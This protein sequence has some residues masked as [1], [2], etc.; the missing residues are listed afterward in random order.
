MRINKISSGLSEEKLTMASIFFV[1]VFIFLLPLFKYTES[2]KTI[3]LLIGI[4]ASLLNIFLNRKGHIKISKL[5]MYIL[6][7]LIVAISS[8]FLGVEK[9]I[10][11]NALQGDLYKF[12][13]V[14]FILSQNITNH[15]KFNYVRL[16]IL[17]SCSIFV[18]LVAICNIFYGSQFFDRS[19]TIIGRY[20]YAFMMAL[21]APFLLWQC[22]TVDTK[23]KY[24]STICLFL[25]FYNVYVS[26]SRIAL[27]SVLVSALLLWVIIKKPKIRFIII[28]IALT[29]LFLLSPGINE[30]YNIKNLFSRDQSN[31][32]SLFYRYATWHATI[33]MVKDKP[34]L[35]FG[36]G[37]KK[38][39]KIL[40]EKYIPKWTLEGD[41]VE[42]LNI[43]KEVQKAGE[44]GLSHPHNTFMGI[45]FETGFIGLAIFSLLWFKIF[46]LT[47]SRLKEND[48]NKP[49][50]FLLSAFVGYHIL[51]LAY[52]VWNNAW[53]VLI[54][55][56]LG[57]LVS[58]IYNSMK[59][60]STNNKEML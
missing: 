57:I 2:I 3:S 5:N 41:K 37:W 21:Y 22:L 56:Y 30:R 25:L 39:Y 6:I 12:I 50:A 1:C 4:G 52:Y 7:Y 10:G 45:L 44:G 53:G 33:D 11:L 58:P 54:W 35:G 48:Y 55:S 40:N 20:D 14:Y 28:L 15:K 51:G 59:H 42:M 38:F 27:I 60:D 34:F 18:V 49:Y 26:L 19:N 9:K 8:I 13:A 16:S 36:F 47:I 32:I 31:I 29:I 43:L 17:S 46:S 24:I 23:T